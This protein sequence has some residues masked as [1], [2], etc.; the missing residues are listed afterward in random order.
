MGASDRANVDALM[1]RA[2]LLA[3]RNDKQ[4]AAE[5][6]GQ[7]VELAPQHA[8][9][10]YCRG[11]ALHEIG[12]P[13]AALASFD[14]AIAL[15]PDYAA[16]FFCRG[17]ALQALEDCAAAL[18]CY[19]QAI[20]LQ[21][22]YPEAHLNRGIVL[23]DLHRLDEALAS[24]DRAI[25]IRRDYGLAYLFRGFTRLLAGDF[26]QGW[27]DCEVRLSGSRH[28]GP[29]RRW[30]AGNPLRGKTI[31]LTDEQGFGDAIQ[32]SR[33]AACVAELGARVVL[34]VRPTLV[35]LLSGIAGAAE[36]IARGAARPD[37]DYECPLMSL[38]LELGTRLDS[39][40]ATRPYLRVEESRTAP[41]LE[42]LGERTRPR[43]GLAWSGSRTNLRDR[44]RSIP[45]AALIPELPAELE[46][47][48][49][50]T[51][52]RE[53]DQQTLALNPHVRDFGRY[54][55]D[56]AE[57]AALCD[58]MDV[59]ISV[60]TSLAHLAG[61]LGKPTWLLVA[62]NPDWRWLLDRADSPWYPTM[63]LYRQE[64]PGDWTSPLRRIGAALRACLTRPA[65]AAPATRR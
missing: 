49:L 17:N 13:Q 55:T 34:E 24:F 41:W 5:L 4:R 48:V 37:F 16:A 53:A 62:F 64:R 25:A 54:Q 31:V 63:Q 27:R 38:P 28:P 29:D 6:F 58:C 50:Q 51:D 32:F 11:L 30:H 14:R 43:V 12:N 45:L 59:V 44:V 61:A 8:W 20:S 60:D 36:V 42:R 35:T 7:A 9:A 57:A 18:S 2:L 65:A 26:E 3:Q 52:I 22:Q 19:D 39:I 33:Y 21:E 1:S 40:P 46:Y 10:H 56:F 15:K 23:K 47:V